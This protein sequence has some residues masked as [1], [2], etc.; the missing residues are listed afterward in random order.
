MLVWLH[1]GER[2]EGAAEGSSEM[3]L[4]A[5]RETGEI[6]G[7]RATPELLALFE[8]ADRGWFEAEPIQQGWNIQRRVD[9]GSDTHPVLGP[10]VLC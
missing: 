5:C 10:I 6:E 4:L 2:L 9:P 7:V 8:G 3:I 1:C